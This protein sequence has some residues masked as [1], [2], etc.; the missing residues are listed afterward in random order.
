MNTYRVRWTRPSCELAFQADS[1]LAAVAS[2]KSHPRGMSG[3]R[4]VE[5]VAGKEYQESE[6][7]MRPAGRLPATERYVPLA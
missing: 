2:V 4:L 1:D 7:G 6:D 3:A 5:V